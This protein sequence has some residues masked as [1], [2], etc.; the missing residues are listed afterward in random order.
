MAENDFLS[1]DFSKPDFLKSDRL[2][3]QRSNPSANRSS[4]QPFDQLINPITDGSNLPI[5]SAFPPTEAATAVNS[6]ATSRSYTAGSR[7]D[8]ATGAEQAT[9]NR[10]EPN[11]AFP[12]GPNEH[13]PVAPSSPQTASV[14][15]API[16]SAK[17]AKPASESSVSS[18]WWQS[19][20]LKRQL[21]LMA[22]GFST[23]PL[24][25]IGA[26]SVAF[27]SPTTTWL[28]G[29][30]LSAVAAVLIA[31]RFSKRLL[32]PI[33]NANAVVNSLGQGRLAHADGNELAQL[34]EKLKQLSRQ[35]QTM[36]QQQ[37]RQTQQRQLFSSISFR[38][39]QTP[40]LEVLQESVVQGARQYL[41]VERVVIYRF[42][43]DWTGTMVAEALAEG[44]PSVFNETIG[45]PCFRQRYITP[46]Q[47][48]R[49]RAINDIYSEPGLTDCYI[50]LLEQYQVRGNLVV[51]LRQDERLYGLLIAHQCSGPRSWTQGDVNFMTQLAA[52]FESNLDL[53]TAFEQQEAAVQRAWLFGEIAF[54]ARQSQDLQDV[55]QVA[56]QGVRQML[57][58]DRVLIYRFNPDWSG[59]MVAESVEAGYPAV[60][61]EKI[62]DPCFRGR[63]VELYRNGRVRAISNIRQ[64]PGLTDCHIR[65]LEKYGVK[66]NLVAPLRQNNELLGL[67]IAHECKAP[68]VWQ[69]SEQEVFSQTAIQLEYA[70]DHLGFIQKNQA[71]AGR[72]RLFGDIAFRARQSLNRSDIFKTVVQ[73]A[74][75]MLQTDRV[76]VYQFNSDW[77]G[78][79]VA[80]AVAGDFP[81]VLDAKIDDPCFRGRYVELYRN[82]RVRAINNIYEEPGLSDCHIRTLEQY[83]VKANL[84]APIRQNNQLAG[85]LI[86]HHCSGARIWQK[87]EI[88]FFSE[89]AT[90]LE[91]ALDH[92]HFIEKLDQARQQAELASQEQRHQK[93]AI[94]GQLETLLSDVQGAFQ[95]DLTVRSRSLDGE[96]GRVA[97]F[98][99]ATIENLQQIVLQVQSA[100]EATTQTACASEAEVH[101]LSAGALRQA[102][103]ITGALGQ[104]QVMAESMQGVAANAQAAKQK[105]QQANQTLQDGDIAMNR[106]VDGILAIQE[107]VGE[108]AQKVKRLG[109]AS[110]KISRV[111]SLIR[112]LANQTHVLALNA[113][114]E[115]NGLIGEG[116]GFVVVAEEVRSLAERST[117]ATR[118]IEQI[119][120]EIQSE[121]NQVV[122]AMEAGLEQ[123]V[124]GTELV[125]TTRQKLTSIAT[126]SGEIHELVE[127]MA[128]AAS[129][130]TRTSASVTGSMQD[131]EVIAQATSEQSVR[132]SASFKKLLGVAQALQESVTRFKVQ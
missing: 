21:A 117:T 25:T 30:G 86:A 60:L 97:Q 37:G 22:I 87:P 52:E 105:V 31:N 40:K 3:E 75:R 129:A 49:V 71:I 115:A 32:R 42:N 2:A 81:R 65:T 41:G 101:A 29:S 62:D 68:R 125:E 124:S 132:V 130:Q 7:A 123:V 69:P 112:D 43:P 73:G 131:V 80:E 39:R 46:Y 110:Q 35:M 95:G 88:D 120:E 11:Q 17:A 89:L 121:T 119:V 27:P 61:S 59:T 100:A 19:L 92:I 64:E 127:Q 82:G 93:E 90:Q 104:L 63:Y 109:E 55:F 6:N 57:N 122:T 45:D 26:A 103:S 70:I 128:Q 24:L 50:R 53:I 108:T 85:L 28:L 77:S 98:L 10:A 96:I 5:I 33:E 91:Y 72:A 56:V 18:G 111:I 54:R 107:T 58:T 67:L 114:I 79:M 76:L 66:A 113:S 83:D 14:S 51:P 116:Q 106:T 23:V 16:S 99:N 47:N 94:Q 48:G 102:E 36:T 126:V 78:T 34:E 13:P 1:P 118:E 9:P 8:S 84:V 44:A 12:T 38:T 4:V 15:T 74:L 20:D